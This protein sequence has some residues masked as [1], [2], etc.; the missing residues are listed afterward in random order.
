MGG[1]EQLNLKQYRTAAAVVVV[2][3][4]VGVAGAILLAN[5]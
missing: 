1:P 5:T 3:V 2:G 4:V